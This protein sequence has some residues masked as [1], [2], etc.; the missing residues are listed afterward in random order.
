MSFTMVVPPSQPLLI[1]S[2][3]PDVASSAEKYRLPFDTVIDAG[4]DEPEKF[5][6]KPVKEYCAFTA[7]ASISKHIKNKVCFIVYLFRQLN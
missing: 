6:S 1:Q 3:S 4:F 2:S 5:R 7:N